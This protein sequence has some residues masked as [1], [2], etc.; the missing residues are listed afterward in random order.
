MVQ[1]AGF[2]R[3]AEGEK[4][5]IHGSRTDWKTQSASSRGA[6]IGEFQVWEP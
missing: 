1:L 6:A 5:Y 4:I 3:K 2:P